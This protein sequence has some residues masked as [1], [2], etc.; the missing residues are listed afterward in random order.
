MKICS[1]IGCN[2]EE[3]HKHAGSTYC[4]KHYIWLS[5]ISE[6]KKYGKKIPS[7]NEFNTLWNNLTKNNFHCPSCNKKMLIKVNGGEPRR[8]VI[9]LQHWCNGEFGLICLSCNSRHGS[10]KLG[11]NWRDVPNGY[12]YCGKC[13]KI[14]TIK[15]FYKSSRAFDGFT[16][17]CKWCDGS[18]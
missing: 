4:D 3:K 16:S 13:E 10:S 15:E 12:K 1:R 17:L 2:E 11:D 18:Y 6:A 14:K 7:I 5:K 8:D 9:S